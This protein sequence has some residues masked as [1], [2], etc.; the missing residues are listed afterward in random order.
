MPRVI[1]P[2]T[3]VTRAVIK[4]DEPPPSGAHQS[5]PNTDFRPRKE[6][7]D[8]LVDDLPSLGRL[9]EL[10][11]VHLVRF[12]GV[13]SEYERRKLHPTMHN[14]RVIKRLSAGQ[15]AGKPRKGEKSISQLRK[16]GW[17]WTHPLPNDTTRAQ[18][19]GVYYQIWIF[20]DSP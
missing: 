3:Y 4:Q 14:G 17:L 6:A 8:H 13:M 19:R 16:E 18:R 10:G 20:N 11:M 15:L 1:S 5:P 7:I 12:N 2:R 9:L